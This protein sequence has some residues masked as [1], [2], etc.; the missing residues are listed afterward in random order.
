[1]RIWYLADRYFAD[2][3]SPW[4]LRI[5]SNAE[6]S[7]AFF[8]SSA[9]SGNQRPAIPVASERSSVMAASPAGPA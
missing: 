7:I 4:T 6:K 1:M 3:Y 9:G 5:A 8:V 2:R